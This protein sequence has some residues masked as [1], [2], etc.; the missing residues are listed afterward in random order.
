MGGGWGDGWV[1][2]GTCALIAPSAPPPRHPRPTTLIGLVLTFQGPV[3]PVKSAEIAINS[4]TT[5]AGGAGCVTTATLCNCRGLSLLCT[6]LAY[7]LRLQ[8]KHQGAGQLQY[9]LVIF[10]VARGSRGHRF[11]VISRSHGFAWARNRLYAENRMI[12]GAIEPE[13]ATS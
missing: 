13:D 6:A 10:A 12:H 1:Y 4:A 11:S 7:A 2:E 9:A 8:Y 3:Q 5:K